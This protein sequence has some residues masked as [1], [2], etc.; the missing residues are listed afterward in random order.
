MN[1]EQLKQRTKDFALRVMTLV[2]HLP[3]NK[4]GR[5]LGDQ[6]LRSVTSV[7]AN[8]RAA[9]RARSTAE[10]IAKLGNVLEEA[11]ESTLWMELIIGG[12]L[13]KQS[14]VGGLLAEAN[15]RAAIMFS[16]RCPTQRNS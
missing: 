11:D 8:Y 5:I 1:K 14:R 3:R 4:K 13:L 10:F 7:A 9:C 12:G 15:E 6:L 16:A 2:D